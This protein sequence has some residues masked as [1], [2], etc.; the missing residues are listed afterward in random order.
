MSSNIPMT[1]RIYKGDEL[2]RTEQLTQ[3]IIK[4]GVHP[5][6]HLR[7]DDDTVSRMHAVIEVT[8]PDEIFIIDLGSAS[9]TIVNGKKVNKTKLESGDEIL[10]GDTKVVVDIGAAG[11]E[12]AAPAIAPANGEPVPASAPPAPAAAAAAK[13]PVPPPNPFAAPAVGTKPA[14]GGVPNPFAAPV[15]S[16]TAAAASVDESDPENVQYGIVASGP[17]VSPDEVESGEQAVEVV[18]M[19]GDRQVLHVEHLNPFRPF[20]VGE[21]G[22]KEAPVDFLMGSDVLGTNRMPV[23]VAGGAGVAVVIPQGATGEVIVGESKEGK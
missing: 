13:A 12:D 5:S 9:G 18:I 17:P 11:A 14:P 19:W 22:G 3:E 21:P 6:S 20:Y 2:V 7:I 15:A 23:V 4:V 10:L 8:G 1:F 16:P